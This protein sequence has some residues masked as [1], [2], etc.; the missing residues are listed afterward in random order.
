MQARAE[1]VE[2]DKTRKRRMLRTTTTAERHEA[3]GQN[4]KD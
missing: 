3:G 4:E 2:Q 1:A